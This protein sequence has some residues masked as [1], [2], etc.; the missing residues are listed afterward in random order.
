MHKK[1]LDILSKVSYYK[2]AVANE[3]NAK[4]TEKEFEKTSKKFLTNSSEC[5]IIIWLCDERASGSAANV[6]Y[7]VN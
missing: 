4:R 7:L 3:A 5:D 2:Q 1:T 6:L